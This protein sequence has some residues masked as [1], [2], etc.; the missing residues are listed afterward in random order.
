M[1]LY[2]YIPPS[3]AHPPGVLKG[4]IAGRLH[5]FNL[6]C[7][8]QADK[9]LLCS[10][11]YQR[12]RH[13]GYNPSELDSIFN[14][15]LAKLSSP[16]PKP[17]RDLDT[18]IILHTKFHPCNPSSKIIQ[19]KFYVHLIGHQDGSIVNIRNS[20]GYKLDINSLIV[21][22]HRPKNLGNYLSSRQTTSIASLTFHL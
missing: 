20:H 12:L 8:D 21:A 11:L 13:R 16:Q 14:Q 9:Q 4:L 3:S 17:K 22:Y 2:L 19:R 18:A 6:L 7:S 15:S 5:Q 10:K 1:N